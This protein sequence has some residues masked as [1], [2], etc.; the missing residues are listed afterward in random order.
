MNEAVKGFGVVDMGRVKEGG[1]HLGEGPYS[2]D[3]QR[4]GYT[5]Q[6]IRLSRP[7][8]RRRR[9][10]ASGRHLRGDR[11]LVHW[12]WMAASVSGM[13]SGALVSAV[14]DAE[15]DEKSSL[16]AAVEPGR[17]LKLIRQIGLGTQFHRRKSAH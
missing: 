8:H 4:A 16:V 14:A 7:S 17:S 9:Q 6:V 15:G 10:F 13:K 2:C 12:L 11:L 3:N 1:E 5:T